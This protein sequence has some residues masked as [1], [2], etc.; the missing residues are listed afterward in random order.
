ME[1]IHGVSKRQWKKW[2]EQEQYLFHTLYEFALFH[3][4]FF[5]HPDAE[6]I[7]PEHWKTTAWNAAW[8]AA[9]FLRYKRKFNG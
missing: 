4:N 6:Y 5:K 2:N 8:Q 1:N 9:D 3:Q 7:L